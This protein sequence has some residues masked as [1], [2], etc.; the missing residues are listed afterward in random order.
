MMLEHCM[1]NGELCGTYLL[2][3]TVHIEKLAKE[4]RARRRLRKAEEIGETQILL[5]G[6]L[7][8]L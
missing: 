3:D 1:E 8:R 4:T 5:L 7:L 2:E 6:H